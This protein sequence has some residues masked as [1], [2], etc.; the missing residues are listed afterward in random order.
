MSVRLVV[1]EDES[2]VLK[3]ITTSLS[4]LGY[5][6]VGTA[7]TGEK[8]IEIIQELKPDLILLDIMLKGDLSGIDVSQF[9]STNLEIPTVFLTAYADSATFSDAKI[10]DPYGYILKPFKE[11]D[12]HNTIEMA[13]H[14]FKVINKKIDEEVKK[15]VYSIESSHDD[16][17]FVKNNSRLLKVNYADFYYVEALK[18][19]VILHTKNGK[20][21]IHSTMKQIES[22]LSEKYF[23]RLHRS[24]IINISKVITVAQGYVHLQLDDATKT[25]KL[26]VG[27]NYRDGLYKRLHLV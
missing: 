6:V 21:T 12:L 2:I 14:K 20:Y 16:W 19:Y 18:D 10:T 11:I 7:S 26:P 4:K 25:I 15:A 27:G 3:D 9:V 5:D 24:Y 1:V 23:V 17:I 8:A 13:L 22:K